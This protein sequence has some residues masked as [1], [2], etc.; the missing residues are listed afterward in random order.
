M[1]KILHVISSPVGEGS[2]S[3][4]LGNA[5]V[6]KVKATN[7]GSTVKENNLVTK[8]YPHLVGAEIAAFYTPEAYRT[9]ENIASLKVS[10]EAIAELME[11]DVIVIGAPLHNFGI[12]SVLKAWIDHVVRV[13]VT[14]SM[15]EK[16]YAGLIK[17]GKKMY[18]AMA[19]GGI[20][21]EGAMQAYDFNAPYLKAVFG[22]IGITD[23][24]VVRAEGTSMPGVKDTALE[25]AIA[26]I[27]IN[28][29]VL[30]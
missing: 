3:I 20:Y 18:I 22:F 21:S 26:G 2:F 29:P 17:P 27:Q 10:D 11:A 6:E 14:F 7:P 4:K 24:T 8:Q 28:T 16:G 23:V 19:S 1:K 30:N 5:I 25:K 12:P 13:G 15:S 9:P